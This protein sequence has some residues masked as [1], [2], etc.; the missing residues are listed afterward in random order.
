M[1]YMESLE[2]HV[3]SWLE[4]SMH[5]HRFGGREF[6]YGRAEIGH[7]HPGG[8]VDIPFPRPIRDALLDEHLAEEHQWVPNSGWV[9]FRVRSDDNLQHAMWL[10]RLSYLRYALKAA[11]D[12][13]ELFERES[14]KLRLSPRFRSLIEPL[15][16]RS[17]R[18]DVGRITPEPQRR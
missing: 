11:A 8:I 18:A 15:F 6:R 5:P 7:V 16:R 4:V 10:L 2:K 3:C 12:P 14:E 1:S 13:G 9:T 17:E